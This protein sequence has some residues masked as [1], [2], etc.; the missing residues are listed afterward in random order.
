M[1]EIKYIYKFIVYRCTAGNLFIL[2]KDV[3]RDNNSISSCY[4]LL[5]PSAI[6]TININ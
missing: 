4:I 1:L 3:I 6:S 2:L 5:S